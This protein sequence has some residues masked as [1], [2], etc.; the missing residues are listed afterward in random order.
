LP[1]THALNQETATKRSIRCDVG[2]AER[3]VADL[4]AELGTSERYFRL[5]DVVVERRLQGL[6]GDHDPSCLVLDRV[7]APDGRF[8]LIARG[9]ILLGEDSGDGG[10][11]AEQNGLRLPWFVA[12]FTCFLAIS[13]LGTRLRIAMPARVASPPETPTGADEPAP[14]SNSVG[15]DHGTEHR[16]PEQVGVVDH[17]LDRLAGRDSPGRHGPTQSCGDNWR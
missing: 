10:F 6:H 16:Q 2:V 1:G 17:T 14:P 7:T 9:E 8:I 12:G 3:Q 13:I 4:C 11:I 15:V 5:V